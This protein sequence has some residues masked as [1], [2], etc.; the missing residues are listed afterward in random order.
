MTATGYIAARDALHTLIQT[1]VTGYLTTT[2]VVDNDDKVLD[3]GGIK[4]AAILYKGDSQKQTANVCFSDYIYEILLHQIVR[5]ESYAKT[6][7]NLELFTEALRARIES[8]P[9]MLGYKGI[10][11]TG[12]RITTVEAPQPVFLRGVVTQDTIPVFF[13]SVMHVQIEYRS[14]ITGGE[15]R[16]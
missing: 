14:P 3:S 16:S 11:S 10:I 5:F 2:N 4:Y 9:A 7:G 13:D 6:L 15:F 12:T 1:G 8:N